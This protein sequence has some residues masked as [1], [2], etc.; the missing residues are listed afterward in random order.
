MH[1]VGKSNNLGVYLLLFPTWCT[2]EYCLR[3][4]LM[5]KLT[6]FLHN[7]RPLSSADFETK[8]QAWT[9]GK[10]AGVWLSTDIMLKC[11]TDIE[12]QD[13]DAYMV[14][15]EGLD[16]IL[17]GFHHHISRRKLDSIFIF[18]RYQAQLKQFIEKPPQ[19]PDIRAWK[20]FLSLYTSSDTDSFYEAVF[21]PRITHQKVTYTLAGVLF[22]ITVSRK[23]LKARLAALAANNLRPPPY[24]N[25]STPISSNSHTTPSTRER[26]SARITSERCPRSRKGTQQFK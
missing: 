22:D 16:P 9:A 7:R 19:P 18:D 8:I 26:R 24:V 23:E 10:E 3:L 5:S 21:H 12:K 11:C 17:R 2:T 4:D 15:G 6:I 20:E 1:Q 13:I 14:L 25:P